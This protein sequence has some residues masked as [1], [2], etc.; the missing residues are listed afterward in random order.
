M[1]GTD[2]GTSGLLQDL[3]VTH[4]PRNAHDV[5]AL[6]HEPT[7]DPVNQLFSSKTSP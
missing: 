5:G 4:L 6:P 2:Q 1:I 7:D 3:G